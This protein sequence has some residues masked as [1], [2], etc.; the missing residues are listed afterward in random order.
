MFFT[1]FRRFSFFLFAYCVFTIVI[2][3]YDCPRLSAQNSPSKMYIMGVTIGPE[4]NGM[5]LGYAVSPAFHTGIGMGFDIGNVNGVSS[6]RLV[7]GSYAKVLLAGT[8]D[9][10]PFIQGQFGF[11]AAEQQPP[12]GFLTMSAGAQYFPSK[13]FSVLGGVQWLGASFGQNPALSAG[14]QSALLGVEW[15]F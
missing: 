12:I 8:K 14:I 2:F 7:L 13:S 9:V 15:F 4:Q 10:K 3:L 11:R 6:N 5:T 1:M